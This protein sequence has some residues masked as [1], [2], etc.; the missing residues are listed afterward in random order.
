MSE[1]GV[2]SSA[3]IAKA[4]GLVSQGRMRR[5]GSGA[6]TEWRNSVGSFTIDFVWTGEPIRPGHLAILIDRW[7]VFRARLKPGFETD[8]S[9]HVLQL[10][11]NKPD[12]WRERFLAI[13]P[14]REG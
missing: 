11:S 7:E 2:S 12:G 14:P 3:I 10:L 1:T 4:V 8:L 13:Q 6:P 5:G 9:Q